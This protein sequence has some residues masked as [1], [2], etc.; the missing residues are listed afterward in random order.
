MSGDIFVDGSSG[1]LSPGIVWQQNS[2]S[3][4]S[5]GFVQIGVP[6]VATST[7]L[8]IPITGLSNTPNQSQ[9]ILIGDRLGGFVNLDGSS[10]RMNGRFA[11]FNTFG[12]TIIDPGPPIIVPNAAIEI[13]N[14]PTTVVFS[15]GVIDGR[16]PRGSDSH[17]DSRNR[18]SQYNRDRYVQRDHRDQQ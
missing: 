13:L 1:L 17:S 8:T 4:I 3:F 14:D 10:F 11:I 16:K 6:E 15:G 12:G 18:D 5:D 9:G 2:G 7:D